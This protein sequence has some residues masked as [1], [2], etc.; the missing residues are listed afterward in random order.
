[1][2]GPDN[3][4]DVPE[5]WHLSEIVLQHDGRFEDGGN[6]AA[7]EEVVNEFCPVEVVAYMGVQRSA[8]ALQ[9]HGPVLTLPEVHALMAATWIDAFAAGASYER[10]YGK[11]N[12]GAS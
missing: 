1:M 11:E 10:R 3:R 4:P 7:L 2:P 12:P 9:G 8:R 6:P 5:F